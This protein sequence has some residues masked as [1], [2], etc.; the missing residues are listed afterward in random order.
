MAKETINAQ[1]LQYF[2]ANPS[3]GMG[4]IQYEDDDD[5]DKID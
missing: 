4:E 3:L 5:S 1:H 2:E